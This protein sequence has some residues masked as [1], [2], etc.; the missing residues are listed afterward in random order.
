VEEWKP[1]PKE[2]KPFP[3]AGVSIESVDGGSLEQ[4]RV[5]GITMVGVRAPIFIRAGPARSGAASSC[6]G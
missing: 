6:R 4:V 1:P 3:S 2:W 5:S